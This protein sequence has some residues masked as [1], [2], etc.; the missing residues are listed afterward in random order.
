MWVLFLASMVFYGYSGLKPLAAMILSICWVYGV[1]CRADLVPRSVTKLLV[2]AGP[3]S[4]LFLFRYLEFALDTL[5][6]PENSRQSFSIFL[7]ILVPAGISFYTFQIIAFGLDVLDRVV[8]RE[9]KL[10]NLLTF[11]S[12]FPQ[13]IAGPIV[14]YRQVRD[15]FEA[16][17]L[18]RPR[19]RNFTDAAQLIVIG[20]AYK[21]FF[22]DG[23][24]L[25]HTK[26]NVAN[27]ATLDIWLSVLIYSFQI[28]YDFFGYSLIAIGLGKLFCIELP[29]NFDRPYMAPNPKQFWRLLP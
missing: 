11:V 24:G 18:G 23:M 15:Q 21:V 10:L 4:K 16:I 6:V 29:I 1:T 9:P 25:L 27:G 17:R 3:L 13:L 28:Y 5:G 19:I 7:D 8:D 12:F 2:V 14:R 26:V 22:A 20:L